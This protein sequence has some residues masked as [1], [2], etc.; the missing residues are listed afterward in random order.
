MTA[1]LSAPLADST[2]WV[3]SYDQVFCDDGI[4]ETVHRYFAS[5]EAAVAY[6][7]TFD[8]WERGTLGVYHWALSLDDDCPF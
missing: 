1:S 5:E 7:D 4:P 3:V 8:E 2:T 6:M